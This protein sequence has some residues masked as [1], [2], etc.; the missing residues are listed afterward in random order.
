VQFDLRGRPQDDA[1]EHSAST[2][3]ALREEHKLGGGGARRRC[4]TSAYLGS[5][6]FVLITKHYLG[7]DNTAVRRAVRVAR[8]EG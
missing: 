1:V 8:V 7:D 3:Y 5:S 2:N 6:Q 4:G